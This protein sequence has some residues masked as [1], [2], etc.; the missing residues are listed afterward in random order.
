MAIQDPRIPKKILIY[1]VEQFLD[2]I[3]RNGAVYNIYQTVSQHTLDPIQT[4]VVLYKNKKGELNLMVSDDES[5]QVFHR[6]KK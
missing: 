4:K 3:E 2:K 5:S 6:I 1:K